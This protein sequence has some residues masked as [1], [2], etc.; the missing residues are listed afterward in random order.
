MCCT[1]GTQSWGYTLSYRPSTYCM[2][3]LAAFTPFVIPSSAL[4]AW[5]LQSELFHRHLQSVMM[6]VMKCECSGAHS[7][8]SNQIIKVIVR[9]FGVD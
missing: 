6:R 3:R 2:L 4:T 8:A 1:T 7:R 9:V 5:L